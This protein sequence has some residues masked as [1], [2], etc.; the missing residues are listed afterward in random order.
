LTGV[1]ISKRPQARS[2]IDHAVSASSYA[3]VARRLVAGLKFAGRLRLAGTMAAALAG[4]EPVCDDV[5]IVPVPPAP[6]R[7]RRRGF[8]PAGEIAARLTAL[9]GNELRQCLTRDD[10]PRQVG[11]PRA[12]RLADPPRVRLTE[13]PPPRALLVD[14][15]VTTGA[16]LAACARALRDGGALS[17]AAVAFAHS[18]PS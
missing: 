4:L 18:R 15:V 6:A 8:D 12:L 10:G 2:G 5:A 1:A 9:I 7:S 14:D 16:T 11:R 3:G 17:V 13:P